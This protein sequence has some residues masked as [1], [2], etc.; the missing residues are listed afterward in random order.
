[1][2]ADDLAPLADRLDAILAALAL[3]MVADDWG[4]AKMAMHALADLT[5]EVRAAGCGHAELAEAARS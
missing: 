1:M 2:N 5:A 4:G 3:A